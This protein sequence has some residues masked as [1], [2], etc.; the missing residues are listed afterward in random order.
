M[1]GLRDPRRPSAQQSVQSIGF[2]S[3][4]QWKEERHALQRY[5]C[6]LGIPCKLAQVPK[7][8]PSC[9]DFIDYPTSKTGAAVYGRWERGPGERQECHAVSANIIICIAP[10]QNKFVE[11]PPNLIHSFALCGPFFNESSST[12]TASNFN[13]INASLCQPK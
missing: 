8:N 7:G 5:C 12:T 13:S 2:A 3:V 9:A 1:S 10:I 11:W 6:Q 4:K